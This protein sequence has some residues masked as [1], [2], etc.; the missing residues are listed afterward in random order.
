MATFRE[1]AAHSVGHL[2]LLYFFLFLLYLFPILVL[3]ASAITMPELLEI[4]LVSDDD[5]S[6]TDRKNEIICLNV[7][8]IFSRYEMKW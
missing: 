4:N 7:T 3:R 6:L 1:I 5:N 2:Y 8:A